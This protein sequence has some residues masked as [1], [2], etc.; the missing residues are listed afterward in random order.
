VKFSSDRSTFHRGLH[1]LYVLSTLM[2]STQ[3]MFRETNLFAV[4]SKEAAGGPV[5]ENISFCRTQLSGCFPTFSHAD[6][7]GFSLVKLVFFLE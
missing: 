6:G 1:C 5:L 4:P 2:Y 3:K 7:N